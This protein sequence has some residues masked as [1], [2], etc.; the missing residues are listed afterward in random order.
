M[1]LKSITATLLL[2]AC[3]PL[4]LAS[5]PA[6]AQ[7][8]QLQ[9]NHPDRYTVQ[10]GDTLW[11]ISGKFL[12]QPWRWPEV[13]RMNRDQIKNPH[14]I[15]PGD[16]VSLDKVDG[17]WR[18]SMSRGGGG[19]GGDR[20]VRVSPSVRIDP[21]EA[22]AIPSIPPGDLAP[23]LTQPIIT[24]AEGLP[25]AAKLIAAR[26]SR[27]VRGEGDYVYAVGIDEK[28]GTEWYIYRPGKT[29]RSFDS[30]ETLGYE[31]RYLGTARVERF[32]EV[33]RMQITARARRD[34]SQRPAGA[35][36]AR[37]AG[38]LRS[39]RPGYP[40]RRTHHR[41]LR[42]AARRQ[43]AASSSSWTAVR[44]TVSRSATCW[45]STIRCR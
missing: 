6:R 40:G 1:R 22:E 37:D 14:W 29:L 25:G 27:V 23:Y 20:Y 10:K 12:K 18:L 30:N 44:A 13:W 38:Q 28:L 8:V 42:E 24:G 34:H 16:V 31:M 43:A 9:E 15:Y 41:A 26:D 19:R 11:G 21:L 39:A 33:S 4:L 5:A 2:S 36:A 45:R 17:Q 35:G 7:D 3:L 32:G